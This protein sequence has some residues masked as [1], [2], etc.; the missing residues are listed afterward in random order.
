MVL[1]DEFQDTDDRE[2]EFFRAIAPAAR[3]IVLGDVNQCIYAEMKRIDPDRRVAEALALPGA[4]R[5]PLPTASQRDPSGVLPAAAD[6][7]RE[8]RFNDPAI[9]AGVRAGRLVVTRVDDATRREQVV[10]LVRAERAARHSVS[11]FTHSNAL[12][13]QLSDDL[14]VAGV[15]HEQ[16]GL[17][18][19]Y[20]EALNAQL[21]MV[22][23]AI[24]AAPAR[25]ALAVYVAANHRADTPLVRQIMDMSNP[26]F[27][28]ALQMVATELQRAGQ[29]GDM[30]LLAEVVEGAYARLGTHRGQQT[31]R[32]AARSTRAALRRVGEGVSLDDVALD[33]ERARH[34]ALLDD[35]GSRARPVQVMNLHQTKGREGDATILLLQ[36]DEY[37]GRERPPYPTLS[38]LLYVVLTRARVR[39]HIVVP[40]EIHPLW[41]PLVEACERVQVPT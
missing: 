28:R 39:A 18:E 30:R 2:W 20:G 11:V 6:A 13:A 36:P 1:C 31:W 15:R 35:T 5:I 41:R 14:T 7:A 8:R 40:D 3:R 24:E 29:T 22:R 33:I 12:T 26:T 38:R 37:H 34:R 17:S 10:A 4:V 21:A 9:L 27:E 32:D 23:Y 19:A 25:R 16:V